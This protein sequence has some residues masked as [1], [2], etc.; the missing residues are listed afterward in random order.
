[1]YSVSSLDS[2]KSSSRSAAVTD[3][4]ETER[5]FDARALSVSLMTMQLARSTMTCSRYA[6]LLGGQCSI[7]RRSNSSRAN[8]A[9]LLS[10]GA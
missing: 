7:H 2:R 4:V 6:L 5:D 10:Q 3:F 8:W 9:P 1:M